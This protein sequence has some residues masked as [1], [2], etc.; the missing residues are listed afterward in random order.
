ME[1]YVI[2]KNYPSH[3]YWGRYKSDW[4]RTDTIFRNEEDAKMYIHGNSELK[5]SAITVQ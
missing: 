1:I 2:Y 3:D 5:Y 4:K